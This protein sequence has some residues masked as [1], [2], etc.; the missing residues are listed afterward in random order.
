MCEL[1][2]YADIF[3]HW[4]KINETQNG[5]PWYFYTEFDFRKMEIL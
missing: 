2:L 5:M 1:T 3:F 4:V